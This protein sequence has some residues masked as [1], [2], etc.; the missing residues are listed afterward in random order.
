MVKFSTYLLILLGLGSITITTV[1]ADTVTVTTYPYQI[2]GSG[3]P[4]LNIVS[5]GDVGIGT[6]SPANTPSGLSIVSG[7]KD[8]L[9]IGSPNDGQMWSINENNIASSPLEITRVGSGTFLAVGANSNVG[10]GTT[11]PAQKLD[12]NGNIRITGNLTSPND[13]C[14][15]AC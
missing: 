2:P 4:G 6:T 14:I 12:V 3:S 1:L 11:N 15:G 13:I 8:Q 7:G 9:R 10:I 5:S